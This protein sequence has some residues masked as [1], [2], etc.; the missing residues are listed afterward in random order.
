MER[1]NLLKRLMKGTTLASSGNNQQ[2]IGCPS[3]WVIYGVM[4]Q[5]VGDL[6]V[7]QEY[8]TSAAWKS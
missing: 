7:A 6:E 1:F 3:R 4:I 2:A 5:A 8:E